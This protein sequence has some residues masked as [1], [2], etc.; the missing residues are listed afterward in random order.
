MADLNNTPTAGEKTSNVS[1]VLAYLIVSCVFFILIGLSIV[2]LAFGS[3]T[4]KKLETAKYD[5][6]SIVP[7]VGSWMGHHRA[8]LSEGKPGRLEDA[9][10]TGGVQRHR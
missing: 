6:A 7:L 8:L 4:D 9:H 10:M 5:F 1:N 3:D 2:V